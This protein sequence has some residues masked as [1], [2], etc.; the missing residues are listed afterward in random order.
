MSGYGA[1]EATLRT[2]MKSKIS[3]ERERLFAEGV[4]KRLEK[5]GKVKV[6]QDALNRLLQGLKG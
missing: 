3:Q 5:E 1:Q 4:R 6:Q 2:E